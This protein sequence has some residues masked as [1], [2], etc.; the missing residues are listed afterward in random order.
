MGEGP[1]LHVP[2]VS[3]VPAGARRHMAKEPRHQAE[4]KETTHAGPICLP[5]AGPWEREAFFPPEELTGIKKD[6]NK[7][8]RDCLASPWCLAPFQPRLLLNYP[9]NRRKGSHTP[10]FLAAFVSDL[11]QSVLKQ[12]PGGGTPPL[13]RNVSCGDL[14]SQLPT[15]PSPWHD[16]KPDSSCKFASLSEAPQA[17]AGNGTARALTPKYAASRST[18]RIFLVQIGVEHVSHLKCRRFIF[19]GAAKGL[20]S[21]STQR[22]PAVSAGGS[23]SGQRQGIGVPLTPLGLLVPLQ[24]D[25]GLK[26]QF[27]G[28]GFV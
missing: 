16:A 28:D 3:S 26:K 25:L 27:E 11:C 1:E 13:S 7:P 14:A 6:V 5:H 8:N 24:N 12:E 10:A 21:S 9:E 23:C 2:L 4:Q 20:S 15:D 18:K 22:A 19:H 17:P